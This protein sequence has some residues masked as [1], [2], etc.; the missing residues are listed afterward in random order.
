VAT[1][2]RD[3]YSILNAVEAFHSVLKQVV[4]NNFALELL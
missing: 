2:P 1:V 3:H 4:D